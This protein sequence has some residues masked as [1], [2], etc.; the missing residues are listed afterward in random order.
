M[1]EVAADE[2]ERD[3]ELAAVLLA[4]DPLGLKGAVVRARHGPAR[5]AWRGWFSE[6]WQ[7][8]PQR[9]S[10]PRHAGLDRLTG[11]IDVAATL[12]RGALVEQPG[13]LE[14]A[15][16]AI[17]TLGAGG[18]LD[19]QIAS[20]IA[21]FADTDDERAI[22]NAP[23]LLVFDEGAEGEPVVVAQALVDRLAF[24]VDISMLSHR[25]LVSV[26]YSDE[27]VRDAR[28]QLAMVSISDQSL[29]A[30]CQASVRLGIQSL[31]SDR[32]AVR[33]AMA[34]AALAGRLVVDE[35]DLLVA[36][37]L[38]LLPRASAVQGAS[39]SQPPDAEAEADD[40]DHERAPEPE[41]DDREDADRAENDRLDD[42]LNEAQAASDDDVSEQRS[43]GGLDDISV[44][45]EAADLLAKGLLDQLT[46]SEARAG[47]VRVSGRRTSKRFGVSRGKPMGVRPVATA[48]GQRLNLVA[49][50]Q[51]AAPWQLIRRRDA[52]PPAA[53]GV[54]AKA[55]DNGHVIVRRQDFRMT[56]YRQ[57]EGQTII[58]AVDASGSTALGRLGEAKGA[59][60]LL[61]GESY[62]RRDEVA[63][64]SF[65]DQKA[66]TLL[67]PT[68]SLVR[69]KRVL[70]SLTGGGGTPLA[71]G[72]DEAATLASVIARN[73]R[74]PILVLIS[75]GRPNIALDGRADRE[76]AR[77]DALRVA[78][79]LR[80]AGWASL[81]FDVSA[82]RQP[83]GRELADAMG[84]GYHYLPVLRSAAVANA[85]RSALAQ[86]IQAS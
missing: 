1:T 67:V 61:L 43:S 74:S 15:A 33:C 45:V 80:G 58:F 60:E 51:A 39:Q 34:S 38:V 40:R 27:D 79:R 36:V 64:I 44:D 86:T 42:H 14:Q 25:A 46:G 12:A 85:V 22:E 29:S 69:A 18:D 2:N 59:V 32:L 73:G 41:T 82:R 23:V 30:L 76:A 7:N 4:I 47:N 49:T 48:R 26:R 6:L 11:G 20:A 66:Q 81:V 52:V 63:L 28:R 78:R 31:R 55:G 8:G 24:F 83:F 72:L 5:D 21:A 50:L 62:C 57:A 70:S 56:R 37:R 71:T 13:L 35:A 10:V 16:G 3:A 9:I 54:V 53:G 68:R 19:V 65:R 77:A 75:D 17:V 84:G